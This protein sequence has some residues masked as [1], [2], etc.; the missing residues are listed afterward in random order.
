MRISASVRAIR[1]STWVDHEST[2]EAFSF[3]RFIHADGNDIL[4]L[5]QIGDDVDLGKKPIRPIK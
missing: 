2:L 3:L 4:L 1:V 5:P